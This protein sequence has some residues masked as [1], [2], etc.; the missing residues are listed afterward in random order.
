MSK[1]KQLVNRVRELHE[2]GAYHKKRGFSLK[3]TKLSVATNHLI[4]EAAEL[5]AEI[6]DGSSKNQ[7]EE[8]ADVLLVYLHLL[9][10]SQLE[11]NDV[12]KFAADKLEQNFT[13]NP[14]EILTTTP[15]FTRKNRNNEQKM[16]A[17]CCDLN[18]SSPLT[19]WIE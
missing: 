9:K 18:S 8:A 19:H 15:G 4:E 10:I 5:Q 1:I 12:V 13:L 3:N 7:I 6:L 11:F 14:S 16:C 2:Q 17:E